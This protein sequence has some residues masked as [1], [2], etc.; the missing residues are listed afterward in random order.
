MILHRFCSAKEFEA[1]QRGDMLVNNTDHSKKRGSASTSVGFCFF[2][3]D[4]EEAV[5]W[6]SGIVDLDICM[7]VEVY[8][9]DVIKSRGRYLE[10]EKR[11]PIYREEYCTK[12]YDNYKFRLVDSTTKY[13]SYAPNHSFL[14]KMFPESFV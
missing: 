1:Y 12:T 11:V 6:L 10:A 3:E 14:K 9:S 8:E 7:T 5:H 13:S 4:P 2:T